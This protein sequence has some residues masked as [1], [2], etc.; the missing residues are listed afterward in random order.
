MKLKGSFLTNVND[1]YV[2]GAYE[3][4]ISKYD[5]LIKYRQKEN[6]KWS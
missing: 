1:I 6:G 4:K 2:V 3:G 5:I